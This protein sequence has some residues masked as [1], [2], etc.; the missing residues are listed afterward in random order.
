VILLSHSP[1]E[2]RRADGNTARRAGEDCRL[3]P[4]FRD[5]EPFFAAR[6]KLEAAGWGDTLVGHPATGSCHE[7]IRGRDRR[8]MGIQDCELDRGILAVAAVTVVEQGATR[9]VVDYPVVGKV[10]GVGPGPREELIGQQMAVVGC[11]IEDTRPQLNLVAPR[12]EIGDVIEIGLRIEPSVEYERVHAR[13]AGQRVVAGIAVQPIEGDAR[14]AG[15]EFGRDPDR[16][17]AIA[18][19]RSR[20]L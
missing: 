11:N 10:R 18:H 17:R 14:T 20:S 15:A 6:D 16:R 12:V 7:E 13:A 1:S 8:R 5:R 4:A 2:P 9:S 19:P 3:R